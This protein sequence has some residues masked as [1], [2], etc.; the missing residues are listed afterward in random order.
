MGPLRESNQEFLRVF[1][2]LQ[3]VD[4][5]F[6]L[7]RSGLLTDTSCFKVMPLAPFV[8]LSLPGRSEIMP[9]LFRAFALALSNDLG[10]FSWGLSKVE[11]PFNYFF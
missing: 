8:F 1:H 4:T 11:L 5:D 2:D 6:S 9:L 7:V 3:S 10:S